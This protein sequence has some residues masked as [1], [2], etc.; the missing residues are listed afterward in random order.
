M[1]IAIIDKP[2]RSDIY[3]TT[4]NAWYGAVK[5]TINADIDK[6]RYSDNGIGFD[7]RSS[8]SHPSGGGGQDVTIF[9]ED[10]SLSRK[11]DNRKK[12]IF[13]LGKVIRKD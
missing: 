5:L 12:D 3:L 2:G 7:R 8:F 1:K 13:I 10:M 6:Y 11:I 4:L 9:W